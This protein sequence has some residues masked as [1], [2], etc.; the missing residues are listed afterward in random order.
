LC[1]GPDVFVSRLRMLFEH[2]IDPENPE[3]RMYSM[4][5]LFSERNL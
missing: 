1:G 5:L 4:S 3:V 2:Q